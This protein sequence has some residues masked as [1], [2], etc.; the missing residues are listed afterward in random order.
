VRHRSAPRDPRPGTHGVRWRRRWTSRAP[1]RAARGPSSCNPP[2]SVSRSVAR[3]TSRTNGRYSSGARG[4]TWGAREARSGRARGRLG[5]GGRGRR[6][7]LRETDR[8]ARGSRRR[9]RRSRR[10]ARAAMAGDED[11]RSAALVE[12]RRDLDVVDR[13]GC[14]DPAHRPPRLRGMARGASPYG[15][16]TAPRRSR[17]AA[18]C[19]SPPRAARA[20]ERVGFASTRGRDRGVTKGVSDGGFTLL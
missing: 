16:G 12:A 18:S 7:A 9:W 20:F 1:A 14:R 3:R 15:D 4:R 19:R 10:E 6:G 11:Q 17:A 5:S 8:R 13:G 2:E